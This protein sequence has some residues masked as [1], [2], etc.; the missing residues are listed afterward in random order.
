MRARP[1]IMWSFV[2]AA[3]GQIT[4]AAE[5]KMRSL[6]DMPDRHVTIAR[7]EGDYISFPD[8]CVTG[9][10]RLICVYRVADKHV[11][12]RSRTEIRT[13]EDDGK[14]WSEP[15]VLGSPGHCPRLSVTDTGEVLLITD[16]SP[17]GGALYR[18][19]D[20][21]ETW[22]EPVKTGLRHGIPDR[23]M[24]VGEKSLLTTGHRHVGRAKSPLLG[25]APSAQIMYRSDD[26]GATWFEWA[27]LAFD[28]RL[29]LCEAS[30]FKMPDGSLRA[31]LR[32]NSGVQ[33]PTY[34]SASFNEGASW[35][36]P[37]DSPTIGH[38][39]CAGLLR[40]GKVLVTYRHVG[41]N[42]GNRAWLGDVDRDRSFAPSAFDLGQGAK[43]TER[44]L[45]IEN[46][47]GDEDAVFYSLRPITDPRVA[48]ATLEVDLMVERNE[49]R[50]CG[51][52]LGCQWH[53]FPDQVR[54]DVPGIEPISVDA[55]QPHQYV[56]TYAAG[57]AALAIDGETR[58][59]IDLAEQGLAIDRRRRPVSVGNVPNTY[60]SLGPFHFA[61]NEGNSTWR[62]IRLRID[63][64]RNRQYDW[65][66]RPADGLPNQHEVDHILELQND[67]HSPPGDFGY[68]GWV[69]LADGR[70]FCVAHYRGDADLSYVA[71]TWIEESDFASEPQ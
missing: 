51:V 2:L 27:P 38:R 1:T 20:E 34:V 40:S 10:G 50:H 71:G 70:A 6:S 15:T 68:S 57:V 23:P 33:E 18:S 65:S 7:A 3:C 11:A 67:R 19:S 43:L 45:T 47:S 16:S 46:G 25:Q 21:G 24:R 39:P 28:P 17:V 4:A 56:F 9:S 69:Q 64:P 26:M 59:T 55:T 32:E 35:T 36:P 29:V 5:T 54:A 63:E 42:G 44:E 41:P 13:S 60:P 49:G 31:Y 37:E 53:I 52:H 48:S 12:T 61:E 8:V 14:T 22:S 62:S 66:W 58:L 30:M